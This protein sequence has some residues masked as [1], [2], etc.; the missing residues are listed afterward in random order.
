M[1]IPVP[2]NLKTVAEVVTLATQAA[3]G[4]SI[5]PSINVFHFKRQTTINVLSKVALKNIFVANIITPLLAA[6]NIRYTLSN[7]TIRWIDDATDAPAYFAN[8]AVGAIGA[9]SL[10]SDDAVFFYYKTGL[11][12]R[13]FRGGKHF[14]PASEADTTQDILTG[15]G[16]GR[17]QTLQ[18]ALAASLTDANGNIWNPCVFS[19]DLSEIDINPTRVEANIVTQVLLDLNIGTMRRRRSVTVR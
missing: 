6:I 7:I 15:A 14:S 12:G 19:R 3:G 18:T 10:P 5:T 8:A 11:R 1:P 16:L 9:D 13:N 17:W 2:D 4:S